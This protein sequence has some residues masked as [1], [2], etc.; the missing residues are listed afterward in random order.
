MRLVVMIE[1]KIKSLTITKLCSEDFCAYTEDVNPKP[2]GTST[3]LRSAGQGK[4]ARKY[5]NI[6]LNRSKTV[7]E[8]H[9]K[10]YLEYRANLGN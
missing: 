1:V 4:K 10:E 3:N 5:R 7:N 2:E 9:Y 6:Q 8:L